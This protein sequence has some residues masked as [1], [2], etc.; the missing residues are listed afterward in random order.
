MRAVTGRRQKARLPRRSGKKIKKS[1]VAKEAW[2]R[3]N[4]SR[5]SKTIMADEADPALKMKGKK[6]HRDERPSSRGWIF[7]LGARDRHKAQG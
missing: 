2:R 5:E 3:T 7:F 4:G 6:K 1:G